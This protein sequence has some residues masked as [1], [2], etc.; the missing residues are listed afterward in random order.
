LGT[1]GIGAA[2]VLQHD[3]GTNVNLRRRFS[4]EELQI[5]KL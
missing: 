5:N 3:P 4:Y 1:Y 2:M